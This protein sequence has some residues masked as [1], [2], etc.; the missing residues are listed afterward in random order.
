MFDSCAQTIEG[1][2]VLTLSC[3]PVLVAHIVNLA[4]VAA[5]T[6]AVFLVILGGYKFLTSG[7]DPKKVE[8]ARQTITYAIIGLVLVILSYFILTFIATVTGLN[9]ITSFGFTECTTN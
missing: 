8:G 5:G 7:G 3:I 4:I 2:Q 1:V 6:I 9:C